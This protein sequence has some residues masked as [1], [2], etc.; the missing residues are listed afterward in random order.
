M[1]AAKSRPSPL[2]KRLLGAI[3]LVGG[4]LGLWGALILLQPL[5][6]G[7][8]EDPAEAIKIL[9]DSEGIFALE[10]RDLASLGWADV[11]AG[12]LRMVHDGRPYPF[13]A[14]GRGRDLQVVFYGRPP[15]DEAARFTSASAYFLFRDGDTAQRVALASLEAT[16][17][18]AEEQFRERLLLEQDLRYEPLS[19]ENET[20]YWEQLIAPGSTA[21][22]F[23]APGLAPGPAR[24]SIALL[25]VTQSH[26]ADP[27]HHLRV[28]LNGDAVLDESWDGLGPAVLTAELPSGLLADGDNRL[29]LEAVGDT[30]V[31][32]DIVLL[33]TVALTYT[34]ALQALDDRLVFTAPGEA[35]ALEGFS[36][37]PL[38]LEVSDPFTAGIVPPAEDGQ[39][40]ATTPGG[41]Y[42]A[43]GPQGYGAP[44]ALEPA[45]LQPDLGSPEMQGA[46]Y[47][48]IGPAG[49]LP[50]LEPLLDLRREQGLSVMSVPWQAIVDQFGGGQETPEAI[51]SFLAHAAASWPMPPRFVLLVGDW[52]SDPRGFSGEPPENLLPSYFIYTE[53]GGETTSDVLLAK[54]DGDH[55]PDLAIGRVPARSVEQV[56]V[57]VDKTL[58]YEQAPAA[59]WERRILAIADGQDASFRG[60]A[61]RFLGHFSE[62]FDGVLLTPAR[63]EAGA[64]EQIERELETGALFMSYFGHG[65][66]SQLGKDAIFTNE[67]GAALANA[68]RLPVMI[69]IT[70]LAGLFSHPEVESLSEI[71]LWNPDGGAVASLG[72]TSLTLPPDQAFLSRALVETLLAQPQARLGEVLLA[73]QQALPAGEYPGVREVMDTFLLFGDPALRL[74]RP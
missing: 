7:E 57:F 42:A 39:I 70:C 44:L 13:Q 38:V 18:P 60:D 3:L 22:D 56:A 68:E 63:G 40:Y 19:A 4:A 30:G 8:G 35:A 31:A 43:A 28:A 33:D 45:L 24:L 64:H 2:R 11:D 61:E 25:A 48:A 65:S 17:G 46:D 74:P 58:R 54:L 29:T 67:H 32:A 66:I 23:E 72:A 10:A 26:E 59:G 36:L 73:A 47:L 1:S 9:V 55:W 20:W 34:R 6:T 62:D 37:A 27:D 49:L 51:R 5:L 14:S 21:I 53:F 41:R 71:M 52:T 50:P 15:G 69:N 16:A 12:S